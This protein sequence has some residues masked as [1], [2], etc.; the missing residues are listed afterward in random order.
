MMKY[1]VSKAGTFIL[2]AGKSRPLSREDRRVLERR[3][4]RDWLLSDTQ[5]AKGKGV[6]AS[7]QVRQ[8]LT[9]LVQLELFLFFFL[10]FRKEKRKEKRKERILKLDDDLVSDPNIPGDRSFDRRHMATRP[11]YCGCLAY[12]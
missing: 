3:C 11:T 7:S 2:D 9:W 5:V 10:I 4:V 12:S 6:E 8:H 1:S